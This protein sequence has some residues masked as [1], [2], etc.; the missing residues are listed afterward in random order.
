LIVAMVNGYLWGKRPQV[1]NDLTKPLIQWSAEL[2]SQTSIFECDVFE[3]YSVHAEFLMRDRSR[4]N[5]ANRSLRNLPKSSQTSSQRAACN[6]PLNHLCLGTPSREMYLSARF[7]TAC[8]S[9]ATLRWGR[10]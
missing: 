10:A 4:F 5:E 9:A 6:L 8:L 1:A 7:A 3:P 2:A